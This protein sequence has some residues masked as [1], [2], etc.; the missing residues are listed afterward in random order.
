MGPRPYLLP[1]HSLSLPLTCCC[2]DDHDAAMMM[3]TS[4][5]EQWLCPPPVLKHDAL[6]YSYWLW[7]ASVQCSTRTSA[8]VQ[9]QGRGHVS[10]RG[11]AKATLQHIYTR[12]HIYMC[13]CG[14]A[15]GMVSARCALHAALRAALQHIYVLVFA[16]CALVWVLMALT[17]HD[18]GPVPAP[19][20]LLMMMMLL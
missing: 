17:L 14:A 20:L 15:A 12:Q 19:A 1:D 13:A 5:G 3:M 18:M 7:H 11:G 10:I 8:A 9:Q 6:L 4:H 16:C 2:T